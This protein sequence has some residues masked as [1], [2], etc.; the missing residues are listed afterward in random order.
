MDARQTRT[1]PGGE[2]VTPAARWTHPIERL[3][4]LSVR[5][6]WAW[7]IVNGYKDV[8]NRSRR[9]KHRG[10]LLIHASLAKTDFDKLRSQVERRF[11][12]SV[13]EVVERGG[14]V[15]IVD[16]V[17]C[18]EHP[19]SKWRAPGHF[20]WILAHP[21]RLKFRAC[22]GSLGFFTPQFD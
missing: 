17:G 3:P 1:Q 16:V 7:L 4:A 19:R 22:S 2:A 18:E 8:E 20:G 11:G 21:R 6:P 9:T 13:P 10:P 5:Q 12:V 14:I 15:G